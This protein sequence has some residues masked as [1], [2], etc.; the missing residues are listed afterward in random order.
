MLTRSI[1]VRRLVPAEQAVFDKS[2]ETYEGQWKSDPAGEEGEVVSENFLPFA[3]GENG[4]MRMVPMLGVVW[5]EKRTPAVS[6]EDPAFLEHIDH[7]FEE[8]EE[9]PEEQE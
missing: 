6:Y 5:R 2:P 4:A 8:E 9:E 7:L 1:M 3:T